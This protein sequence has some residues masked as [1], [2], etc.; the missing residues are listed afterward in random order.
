MRK[1]FIMAMLLM[2]TLTGC[3]GDSD[4]TDKSGTIKIGLDDEYAPMGFR[5]EK[6]ELIGFDIDLAKE[7]ARRLGVKAE[8]VPIDWDKKEEAITSGR[9]DM[10]WNGCDIT[11]ERKEYMIFSKPYM[12]NRQILIVKRGNTQNIHSVSD[13][14]G[15]VVGTQA[16]SNSVDYVEQ[17]KDLK[18]SFE[19]FK[20][21]RNYREAFHDLDKDLVD[22]LIADEIV[23]RY[24]MLKRAGK[25]EIIEVTVGSAT[26]I[27]IGFRKDNIELRDK[28]Q[29]VFDEMVKDGTARKISE[30]WFQA[31][32]IKLKR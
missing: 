28:V 30:Q 16:G 12:N 4:L 23:S 6:G 31:D 19:A 8:F 27:G 7:A 17:H 25:F 14:E 21:Y 9:V 11:D 18:E 5:D 2:M 29:K 3:G 22:V 32:L 26:E 13:L 1:I 15:K 10:L 20:T 24:A